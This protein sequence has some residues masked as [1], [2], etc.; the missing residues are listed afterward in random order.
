MDAVQLIGAS[1]AAVRSG[2]AQSK[3][4]WRKTW[5]T[6]ALAGGG[7]DDPMAL[8]RPGAQEMINDAGKLTPAEVKEA[9]DSAWKDY[10]SYLK[11][12]AW[13]NKFKNGLDTASSECTHIQSQ[14]TV[15]VG[16][17]IGSDVFLH[18][19]H[20]Y[21][22]ANIADGLAF[23][24]VIDTAFS[25][26]SGTAVG[27]A[28]I[29]KYVNNFDATD[30]K[31][32]F[33][34]A[35]AYNQAETR[36]EVKQLVVAATSN[37]QEW[38]AEHQ[39]TLYLWMGYI[40]S[41]SKLYEKMEEVAKHETAISST[42]RAV[43]AMGAERLL[44]WSGR[45]LVKKLSS[46]SNTVGG[47]AIKGALLV[48]S[49]IAL[50]DAKRLV[51]EVA[52]WE[53]SIGG[54]LARYEKAALAKGVSELEARTIALEQLSRERR[55]EVVQAL[56]VDAELNIKGGVAKAIAAKSLYGTL[57]IIELVNF[58]VI[59]S[60]PHKSAADYL[61]V[62]SGF[63]SLTGACLN[64]PN[65]WL[66]GFAKTAAVTTLANMKVAASYLSGLGG[67]ISIYGDAKKTIES[68]GDGKLIEGILNGVKAV[69]DFT[70]GTA[71]ILTAMSSSASVLVKSVRAGA[72]GAPKVRFLGRLALG[73]L[74]NTERVSQIAAGAETNVVKSAVTKV[75]T[76][77]LSDAAGQAVTEQVAS[78][79]ALMM[80]GR[81][82]V[83]ASGWEIGSCR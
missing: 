83:I 1:E 45:A 78:R 73:T 58:Y 48:R 23:V 71:Y 3:S 39:A 5:M 57:L 53:S 21:D 8:S 31:S 75:V 26:L 18:A 25:G 4:R 32:Y 30:D 56:Y 51:S 82:L 20:D 22:Q 74:A 49:G 2:A 7:V 61:S 16:S 28:I 59:A 65:K 54:I 19:L 42:E 29:E 35:F 70:S 27:Q 76:S 68:F 77:A 11:D 36:N 15:D 67:F 41:Y 52:T 10:V 63:L 79:A 13:P 9:G 34:R 14:R 44:L 12:K 64:V 37:P 50:E 80:M 55:S 46:I 40:K 81:L 62:G 17:W 33:W 24:R 43:R 60:K 69:N 66:G 72:N 47:A 6:M 38:V